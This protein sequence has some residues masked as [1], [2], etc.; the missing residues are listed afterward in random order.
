M[1]LIAIYLFSL[2]LFLFTFQ[3][4]NAQTEMGGSQ[5]FNTEYFG[6][7]HTEASFTLAGSMKSPERQAL[8]PATRVKLNSTGPETTQQSHLPLAK[9][10]T[11]TLS[12]TLPVTRSLT[13]TV[14]TRPA[15]S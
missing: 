12:S 6:A 8:G 5:G 1:K 11:L 7:D 10:E 2:I 9:L 3:K 14:I 13:L 4:T 15:L